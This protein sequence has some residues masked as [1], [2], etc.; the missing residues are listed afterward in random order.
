MCLYVKTLSLR[1]SFWS[2]W[3]TTSKNPRYF[4][5]DQLL[6]Y[7]F[8]LQRAISKYTSYDNLNKML[9]EKEDFQ[10]LNILYETVKD[11]PSE[12]Q[13]VIQEGL[14]AVDSIIE[15]ELQNTSMI[16]K[17]PILDKLKS[18]QN[19]IHF[20][21]S[22]SDNETVETIRLKDLILERIKVSVS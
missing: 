12:Y 3:C 9:M 10:V 15:E 6:F 22:Q 2:F 11:T 21:E 19:F 5:F 20:L 7:I 16:A 18:D 8:K 4:F 1:S 14:L 17:C 13:E